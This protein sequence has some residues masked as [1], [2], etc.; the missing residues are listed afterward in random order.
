MEDYMTR[1][2]ARTMQHGQRELADPDHL[3][4]V[5]P[6]AW[7]K[8]A[9]LGQAGA[10]RLFRHAVDQKGI[11][12]MRPFDGHAKTFGQFRCT[13]RMIRMAMGNEDFFHNYHL[14]GNGGFNPLQ[15]AT[16]IDDGGA[17]AVGAPQQRA[18]LS[19]AGNGN[20]TVA[21]E[22]SYGLRS[23]IVDEPGV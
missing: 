22:L 20:D 5:Q 16:R 10:F 8:A 1:R 7:G 17:H 21:H 4:L 14:F 11:V 3:A 9:R 19:K 2:M 15:I 6:A 12:P 13:A 23:H 18:I